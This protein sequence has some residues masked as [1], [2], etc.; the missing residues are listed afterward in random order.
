[1][2][3]A[4]GRT[5]PDGALAWAASLRP[6]PQGLLGMV[7]G[8]I[9]QS[10]PERAIE[11]ALGL[12]SPR[13]QM[14]AFTSIA[15]A[16]RTAQGFDAALAERLLESIPAAHHDA[17]IGNLVSMWSSTDADDAVRWMLANAERIPRRAFLQAA[18]QF[19][20]HN[21]LA[22]A[23][24]TER[25]PAELRGLWIG[26]VAQGYAR[27]DLDGAIGW[28]AQYRGQPGYEAAVAAIAQ[29]GA[30]NDGPAAAR[31][32][33]TIDISRPEFVNAA[34]A[35]AVQWAL[36]DPREATAWAAELPNSEARPSVVAAAMQQWVQVDAP[37]ARAWALSL[38]AS[39]MRD[40][41]LKPLLLV[42][43]MFATAPDRALLD[44]H[45][46]DAAR[47]GALQEF[48]F[49]VTQRDRD[50]ARRIVN[51]EIT[52]AALRQSLAQMLDEYEELELPQNGIYFDP[53]G[54]LHVMPQHAIAVRSARPPR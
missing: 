24:Y 16:A 41:A 46:N 19:G 7:I 12:S 14:Q 38:T 9:A 34:T 28:V 26:T 50:A 8:G 43:A 44:A 53:A 31:L 3:A 29:H 35:V 22:A 45:S 36:Q 42:D 2:A 33:A 18:Q 5:D 20:H 49:I 37:S 10:A 21:P 39:P 6:T 27:T 1:V 4:Y 40:S 15:G 52:N 54:M 11:I 51:E 32:L 25:V 13:E 48:V 23:S 17:V 47:D 30:G